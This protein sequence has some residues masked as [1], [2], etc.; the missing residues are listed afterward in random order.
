MPEQ[1]WLSI[2]SALLGI[3]GVLT[4]AMYND[5]R[6]R[7]IATEAKVN[8]ILAVCLSMLLKQE[9]VDKDMVQQ[10]MTAIKGD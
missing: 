5:M 8:V 2:A 10:V 6:Q 9:P 4:I 7:G 1:V 3:I